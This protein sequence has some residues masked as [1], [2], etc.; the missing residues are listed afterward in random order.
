MS[1][2]SSSDTLSSVD[3]AET[4]G[5]EAGDGGAADDEEGGGGAADDKQGGGVAADD[6]M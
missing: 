4:E 2:E 5:A 6:E 3:A 1:D